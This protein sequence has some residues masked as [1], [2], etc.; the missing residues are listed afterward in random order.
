[1]CVAIAV[2]PDRI[3][4]IGYVGAPLLLLLAWRLWIAGIHTDN[5][6]VSVVGFLSSKRFTWDEIDHFA[7]LPFG[8]YP[9]VGHV[10]LRDGRHVPSL[11]IA[12]P[13]RPRSERLR[14]EVER[15]IDDLNR[16]LAQRRAG[17]GR[18]FG[19]VADHAPVRGPSS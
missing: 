4:P 19:G 15:P 8:Q 16:V 2:L 6:G 7:V 5:G 12:S 1:M 17:D 10:V 13:A 3:R 14:V 11:A 9:Y 18:Q